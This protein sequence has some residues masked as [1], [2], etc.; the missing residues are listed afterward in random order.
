M[1][2]PSLLGDM[3]LNTAHTLCLRRLRRLPEEQPEA[4][5]QSL[6]EEAAEEVRH[7]HRPP[8]HPHPCPLPHP[9]LL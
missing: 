9:R 7:R 4:E 3:H 8:R 1:M 6:Q 2:N 5:G